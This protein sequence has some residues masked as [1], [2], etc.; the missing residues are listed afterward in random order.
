MSKTKITPKK[1]MTP[2]MKQHHEI[3]SKYPDAI[4][5][6]RVGDFYETFG[7]DAIIASKV[8]GIVQTKR[9]NGAAAKVELAGFPHHSLDAYLHKLVKAGYRVAICDQLEEPSKEKKIVKRGVTEVVS[10]GVTVNDKLLDNKS[11]NFIASV[12][13]HDDRYG[14]SVVDVS[15]GEFY[16]AEGDMEYIEKMFQSFRPSEI[17]VPKSFKSEAVQKWKSDY[18]IYALNDWVYEYDYGYEKLVAQ[19]GTINLKGFLVED[20]QDAIVAGGA[21]LDYFKSNELPQVGHI[22]NIQR[23]VNEDFLWMDNFTIRNLELLSP[24][25]QNHVDGQSLLSVIDDTQTAMGA[26]MM[27]RWVCFPLTSRHLIEERLDTVEYMLRDPSVSESLSQIFKY[28]G[29]PERLAAKI[30]LKKINPREVL[31]IAYSLQSMQK[32][33]QYVENL[34]TAPNNIYL[35]RLADTI[36]PCTEIQNLITSTL[37]EDAPNLL[38][39]GN[40]IKSGV[41]EE[42]DEYV[43]IKKSGKEYLLE[44]QSREAEKTGITS[45]KV[46]FNNVFGYYLEVTNAHKDKVP[47][48]WIRKQTLTNVERYITEELKHYEEKISSAE[49]RIGILEAEVYDHLI[50]QL[51]D[52]VKPLQTNAHAIAVI[53]CLCSFALTAREREYNK[54]EVTEDLIIDLKQARHPVIESLLPLGERYIPNDILLDNNSQQIIILTGPNMSGKSA[55]LRQTALI[56]LMAHMGAFVPCDSAKIAL[57]DK[58]FTRVGA[59]DNMSAGESTFMVEM[60]ETAGIINNV[61]E[62][63]LILLDEIGRGTSTYDGI[64]LAWSIVEYLHD[65]PYRPKTLFATHY[66]ELNDLEERTDRVQNYHIAHAEVENQ[67]VFTRILEK[68]GSHHSFGIHVA[69]MA[70][71][72]HSLLERATEV[73][74]TLEREK[75]SEHDQN[76]KNIPTQ[77]GYQLSFFDALSEDL[78]MIRDLLEDT[79]VNTI[80]PVDALMK[81]HEL[82]KILQMKKD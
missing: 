26:R 47:E 10:P 12:F 76:V 3:K 43:N 32:L 61:S 1:T 62:R 68:G 20:M 46:G 67:I 35:K 24:L 39:K 69:R 23:I 41:N 74:Q 65:S 52:V 58:I 38:S 44:I 11:N 49:E 25:H 81:L 5:L 73:M 79:D 63:S 48:E 75:S 27:R 78:S 33:K 60:N 71:M 64:S 14:L 66:H 31:Q 37:Q 6:F 70:G 30:P 22:N 59:S 2:L 72:P 57:T 21:I 18:Y 8:L 53:D 55:L 4:L 51:Q 82:K 42:L 29:D 50:A 40:V 17:L 16:M 34:D 7:Q 45:L 77:K 19:F 13:P 54:P 9:S 28:V 56:T 80:T 15:T 36:N